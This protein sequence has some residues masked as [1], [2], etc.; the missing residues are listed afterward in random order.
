MSNYTQLSMNERQSLCRYL[1][2]GLSIKVIS[3][4]LS[5]HR[6]TVYR[7][8]NRNKESSKYLPGIANQKAISRASNGRIS[9]LQQDGYLRDYVI[10]ALKKGWSPEQISGRMK[11]QKL[12]IYVC[13]ETIYQ[14]VY[15]LNNK[16]LYHCLPYKQPKRHKRY[17]RKKHQCR[18]GGDIRLIT[19]RP[20]DINK[21]K[22]FGHWE[23]DTIQFTGN[24]KKVV[25]TLVERKSRMVLLIKNNSKHSRGI[26]EK[27]SDKF[28]SLPQKMCKTMTF[29]QGIEFADFRYLESK[30]HCQVYYCET[31]SPWQKGTNENMNGRLRRYLPSSTI[32][33]LLTQKDLD[34]LADKIN[35]CPRKCLGYKM[36]KEV[37]IQQH[38]NDCRIWS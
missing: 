20:A 36:P 31:H 22:R 32:I 30:M 24:K 13:P 9:K 1:E 19:E 6:S 14:Y 4:K 38:K 5:R 27:I 28:E 25:T 26:M 21:R 16:E 2:M 34:L 18:F 11:Y 12:T 37:F 23:G 35:L 3:Q 15:K 10:K 33:D 29:D 7:E 17:T 8:I